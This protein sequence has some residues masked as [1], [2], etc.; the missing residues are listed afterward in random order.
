MNCDAISIILASNFEKRVLK[1]PFES[2][3]AFLVAHGNWF[4]FG[5]RFG[6]CPVWNKTLNKKSKVDEKTWFWYPFCR[7]IIENLN[8]IE[9]FFNGDYESAQRV[10]HPNNPSSRCRSTWLETKYF[11]NFDCTQASHLA[12][13]QKKNILKMKIKLWIFLSC[14]FSST[15]GLCWC[16]QRC[17]RW[18]Q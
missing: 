18:Y 11:C 3:Q 5:R 14:I 6:N 9:F 16:S 10:T 8:Q 2:A 17:R 13:Y 1:L 15:C 12:K 4:V 7:K